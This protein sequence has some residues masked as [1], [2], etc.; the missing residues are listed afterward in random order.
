MPVMKIKNDIAR[1]RAHDNED[2]SKV[3]TGTLHEMPE[4][5]GIDLDQPVGNSAALEKL[6]KYP[7]A[8]HACPV[9][10]SEPN[11]ALESRDHGGM[12]GDD[13]M[14]VAHKLHTCNDESFD[15]SRGLSG[16]DMKPKPRWCPRQK[17]ENEE[18]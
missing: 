12:N 1:A 7:K 9:H 16:N 5:H 17:P 3:D 8:C 10:K 11:P 4:D 15:R 13:L 2:D 18:N 6:N 14:A